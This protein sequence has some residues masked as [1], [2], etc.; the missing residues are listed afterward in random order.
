[1][2][3]VSAM[4]S[5]VPVTKESVTV[6][7]YQGKSILTTSWGQYSVKMFP[8]PEPSQV[9]CPFYCTTLPF[10][11]HSTVTNKAFYLFPTHHRMF[12]LNRMFSVPC[13]AQRPPPYSRCQAFVHSL[14]D[15]QGL[16][17][18]ENW[19]MFHALKD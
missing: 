18:H 15:R 17:L 13:S 12:T 4:P 11:S 10:A 3:T 14:K 5:T 6:E 2:T 9:Q 8:N 16:Q 7:Q 1:M 19:C